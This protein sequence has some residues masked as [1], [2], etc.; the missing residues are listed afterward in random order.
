MKQPYIEPGTVLSIVRILG[1]ETNHKT[2]GQQ[3]D[4]V[5]FEAITR[6]SDHHLL[7]I[8]NGEDI[9]IF[10][11]RDFIETIQHTEKALNIRLFV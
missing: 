8:V 2:G 3:F 1:L 9:R 11:M 5:D 6:G 7:S 10:S 4:N